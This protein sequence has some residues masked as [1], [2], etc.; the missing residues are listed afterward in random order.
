VLHEA[1]ASSMLDTRPRCPQS[2]PEA[3]PTDFARRSA[4]EKGDMHPVATVLLPWPCPVSLADASAA[5]PFA[6]CSVRPPPP[7]SARLPA[8]STHGSL[9]VAHAC[10]RPSGPSGSSRCPRHRI[11]TIG[12]DPVPQPSQNT[13]K[14]SSRTVRAPNG[15]AEKYTPRSSGRAGEFAPR[16]AC[17]ATSPLQTRIV[18]V[19][20]S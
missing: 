8:L 13:A 5:G 14:T 9:R 6:L 15:R 11:G 1:A 12:F 20:Q 2:G 16:S 17:G 18:F 10:A 7:R 3:E 19:L 4:A